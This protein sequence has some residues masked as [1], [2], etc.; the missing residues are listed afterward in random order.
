MLRPWPRC[1]TLSPRMRHPARLGLFPAAL[2]LLAVGTISACGGSN[3]PNDAG[4]RFSFQ[5]MKGGRN[6]TCDAA[7]GIEEVIVTVRTP[8]DLT[9][10]S[11]YPRSA[12]CASG[13]FSGPSLPAGPHVLDVSA[14]G[15]LQT[16]DRA[17]LFRSHAPLTSP[18]DLSLAI[19]LQPEV[20]FLKVGWTFENQALMPCATEVQSVDVLI[21]TG[22]TRVSAFHKSF[23]CTETPIEVPGALP[24]DTFTIQIDAYSS[25]GVP[26]FSV[27]PSRAL[28]RGDNEFTATLLPLGGLLYLDWEFSI[29]GQIIRACDDARVAAR[30]ILATVKSLEG[31]AS[32]SERVECATP[33]PYKFRAQRFR[34]GR[35]L[36]LT[37]SAD[38]SERFKGADVFVMPDGDRYSRPPLSMRAVGNASA[39][40]AVRTASCAVAGQQAFEIKVT[41]ADGTTPPREVAKLT[42]PEGASQ[43]TIE[44]LAYGPYLVEAA[45]LQN[46]THVCDARGIRVI[47]ARTNVW[48][49]LTF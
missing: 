33:R 13:V 11:G 22:T 31:G 3:P 10:L 37:L 47:A 21:S 32:V 41:T 35:M 12:D 8:D 26:L 19:T 39:S 20:A 24:L 46:G 1:C 16:G 5:V 40:L 14:K 17:V 42:L 28:T 2:M 7:G 27:G 34:R 45:Q 6:L 43:A 49:P 25:E 38:G 48:E 36:E 15:K 44:D 30:E 23:R 4:F 9:V 29:R 18:S